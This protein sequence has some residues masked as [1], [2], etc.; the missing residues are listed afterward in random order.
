MSSHEPEISFII[1]V[2]DQ[3]HELTLFIFALYRYLESRPEEIEI[4]IADDGSS[5]QTG[6]V[7]DRLRRHFKT[8]IL[9]ST[10]PSRGLGVVAREAFMKARGK[11]V[12]LLRPNTSFT[13]LDE[14][15]NS[16]QNSPS[17][18]I[19]GDIKMSSTL[20]PPAL[21]FLYVWKGFDWLF[22]RLVPGGVSVRFSPLV[23]P[24]E[25]AQ[26]I[27]KEGRVS[28]GGFQFELVWRAEKKG[29]EVVLLK[30]SEPFH[31]QGLP[32]FYFLTVIKEFIKM[33]VR[34]YIPKR[35]M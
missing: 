31:I 17:K 15:L 16:I 23:M 21:F 14:I 33:F 8:I 9:L 25:I 22:R 12:V 19:V 18:V 27:A 3:C 28:H 4:I 5:D 13:V 32:L 24:L 1:P 2:R 20:W 10:H 26:E 35:A 30:L 34:A 7:I 29:K 11:S 6:F